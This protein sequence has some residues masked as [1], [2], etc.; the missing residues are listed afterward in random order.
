MADEAAEA[1]AW[2]DLALGH[3]HCVYFTLTIHR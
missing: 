1:A 2:R 3:D